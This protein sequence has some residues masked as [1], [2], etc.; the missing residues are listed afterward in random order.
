MVALA[1]IL[2]LLPVFSLF[3]L[4]QAAIPWTKYLNPL[5][6]LNGVNNEPYVMDAWVI[7]EGSTYKMWYTHSRTDMDIPTMANNLTT[8]ISSP[9]I[10]A[11]VNLDLASLL[12]GMAGI[13]DTQEKMDALWN[14]MTGTT[15]VIGYAE[16]TDGIDWNVVNDEVLAGT[17]DTL[18]S[19]GFPCVINDGGTYKMWFTHSVTSLDKDGLQA[20]LQD[21]DD[22][23][24]NVAR[25]ALID[26]MGST[27]S[28]IGYT[29]SVD[30]TNWNTPDYEVFSGGGGG[31]WNSV[32]TPCVINDSGT[33]KMWY[34]NAST[35]LTADDIY[36]M[37]LDI[38]YFDI[39]DL[40]NILD[41]TRTVISYTE[42]ADGTTNWSAPSVVL[43]GSGGIWDSVA[44]PSVIKNGSSY[45]IWYTS[46]TTDLTPQSI[47][48]LI[49][50]TQALEQ[51]IMN[52][53]DSLASGDWDAFLND[54]DAFFGDPTAIPPVPGIIDPVLPYLA[55]TSTVV[56]HAT[57]ADGITWD[58]RNPTNLVGA[59]GSPWSSVGA[60]CV[61]YN[62]GV[63][64]MWYVQGIDVLT[65]QNIVY[66][67]QGEILP[68][69][70]AYYEVSI[71][72]VSGW[73]FI[74]LLRSPIPSNTEDV[75]SGII[76]NVRT[77]WAYDAATGLWSY[78]TTISGAPQG[79]LT[80]MTEGKA[81][82]IEMT[83]I[84]TLIIS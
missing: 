71:D 58:I 53:W 56:G 7:K 21:L 57:S 51:D 20:I 83:D 44:T 8:I 48:A 2:V 26:L 46:F 82:W 37:L 41:N 5:S 49:N 52:L 80:E 43:A 81:Y 4:I 47:Q 40:M 14:F 73:N 22:P 28:A 69:G 12:G 77:V 38:G 62:G 24:L 78:F 11:L 30:E 50:E 60:P 18:E 25:D 45:E 70:Y 64:E 3:S 75:L 15:T 35:S 65:A 6:L 39:N 10:S 54:L 31:L 68:L 27:R 76:A 72:L 63:Y 36:N 19:I 34:T 29:T 13:G 33:Y 9:L 1:L 23:D 17:P 66:L 79:G 67:L 32:A 55:N 16:S 59:S 84:D 74:G 42:S 61:I